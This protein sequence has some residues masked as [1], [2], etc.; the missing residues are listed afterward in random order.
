[1]WSTSV[2][3]SYGHPIASYDDRS[4]VDAV[5]A[6]SRWPGGRSASNG[7]TRHGWA[8]GTDVGRIGRP[9]PEVADRTPWWK[10]RTRTMGCPTSSS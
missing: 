8:A 10:A 9:G 3:R 4:V 6:L 2:I 1:M 5:A 7:G